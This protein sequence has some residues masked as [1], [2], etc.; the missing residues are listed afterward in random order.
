M[1]EPQPLLEVSDCDGFLSLSEKPAQRRLPRV[2]T[3]DYT[4]GL[5]SGRGV[6]LHVVVGRLSEGR[7]GH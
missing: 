5:V 6:V 4:G 3:F 7:K 2:E 1:N